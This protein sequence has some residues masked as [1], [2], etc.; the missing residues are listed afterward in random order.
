MIVEYPKEL[1]ILG[2]NHNRSIVLF[3]SLI[4]SFQER[5]GVPSR[6]RLGVAGADLPV[7]GQRR[8]DRSVV[9]GPSTF[10]TRVEQRN[11]FNMARKSSTK[12]YCSLKSLYSEVQYSLQISFMS[13]AVYQ[14]SNE[15]D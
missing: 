3:M 2:N 4:S 7:R 11:A 15:Y 13:T 8:K 9:H 6:V 12:L 5:R 1:I 14:I 10:I